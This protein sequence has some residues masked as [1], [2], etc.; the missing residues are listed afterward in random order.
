MSK[1]LTKNLLIVII[2]LITLISFFLIDNGLE[3]INNDRLYI[4]FLIPIF[5]AFI[6]H[7][8]YKLLS[9]LFLIPIGYFYYIS[10]WDNSINFEQNLY[11]AQI[12]ANSMSTD[13]S[14]YHKAENEKIKKDDFTQ[15][16]QNNLKTIEKFFFQ[17]QSQFIPDEDMIINESKETL[18]KMQSANFYYTLCLF[19]SNNTCLRNLNNKPENSTY[20]EKIRELKHNNDLHFW[21][22]RNLYIPKNRIEYLLYG[23]PFFQ[24]YNLNTIHG[25]NNE[26]VYLLYGTQNGYA[27]YG[28]NL[29]TKLNTDNNCFTQ[30]SN[31]FLWD[32]SFYIQLA[33]KI[34]VATQYSPKETKKLLIIFIENYL[35]NTNKK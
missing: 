3:A 33:N 26:C 23:Y 31:Y 15:I 13:F 30:L 35:K 16:E 28:E 27:T 8:K 20:E 7:K 10:K 11:I 29:L 5:F 19:F 18:A 4:L 9:L 24:K 22:Y 17:K 34:P 25:A 12:R 6:T 21:Y 32:N 1:N 14:E 2:T